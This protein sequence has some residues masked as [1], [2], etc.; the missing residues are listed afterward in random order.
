[1]KRNL[2]VLLSISLLAGFV[3][4]QNSA[5]KGKQAIV[6]TDVA[7]KKGY[8]APSFKLDSL[9]DRSYQVGGARDKPLL[10]N[11]WAS[12]CGPCSYEAPYIQA[13]FEKY[14]DQ[15]DIY[16]VNTTKNDFLPDVKAMVSKFELKFPILLDKEGT[17]TNLY[18]VQVLPTSFF[19]DKQGAIVD[20]AFLLEPEELE[21]KIKNLIEQ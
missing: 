6:A 2:I 10:L 11:Y 21:K 14:K 3:I 8:V 1:M 19:I 9:D 12:W 18:N 7:P 4:Y 15:I 13:L 20:V 17:V 16:G 5:T